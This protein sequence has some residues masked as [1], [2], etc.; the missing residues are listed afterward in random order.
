M[1]DEIMNAQTGQSGDLVGN[2]VQPNVTGF[3]QASNNAFPNQS[4]DVNWDEREKDFLAKAYQQTQ[5]MISQSENR[6]SSKYQGM[7]DQFKADYGV[8][9]TEEQAQAMAQ[10]QAAKSLQNVSV[11]A[12]APAQQAPAVDSQ[13]QGF[14]YYH[15]M[16]EKSPLAPLYK[17]MYQIQNT[18][19]VQLEKSDEEYQKFIHPEVKYK[20]NEFVNAWKQACIDKMVR[21]QAAQ[22]EEEP[23]DGQQK[24]NLGQM[25]LVGSHGKKANTYDPKRTTKSYVDEYIRNL[26]L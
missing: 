13:Y 21:M 7:I 17:Q 24:T 4:P 23:A 2:A 14:M 18:L 3:Q 11:P 16:D 15:G 9:L 5:R 12:Q 25:P 10:N 26:K 1:S 20:P 22:A 8:T 6:Q 19:G